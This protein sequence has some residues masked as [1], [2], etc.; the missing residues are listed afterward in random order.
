MCNAV[1]FT[2]ATVSLRYIA[3]MTVVCRSVSAWIP[4]RH[5]PCQFFFFKSFTYLLCAKTNTMDYY[6]KKNKLKKLSFSPQLSFRERVRFVIITIS[7]H[8]LSQN[9][10]KMA[11]TFFDWKIDSVLILEHIYKVYCR[12]FTFIIHLYMPFFFLQ[13]VPSYLQLTGFL[14]TGM[15]EESKHAMISAWLAGLFEPLV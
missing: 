3:L 5:S 9:F 1:V 2:E 12:L 4:H 11:S 6:G 7:N 10:I 13:F 15:K 8:A 14:L